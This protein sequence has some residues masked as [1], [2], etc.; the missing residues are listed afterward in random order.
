M[1]EERV[2][3]VRTILT[4]FAGLELVAFVRDTDPAQMQTMLEG[5]RPRYRGDLG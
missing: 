1:S 3:T 4:A 5:I 2:E